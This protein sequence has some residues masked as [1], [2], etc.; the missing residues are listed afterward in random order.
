MIFED[1]E[2]SEMLDSYWDTRLSTLKG[3]FLNNDDK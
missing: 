2:E 1:S 3:G